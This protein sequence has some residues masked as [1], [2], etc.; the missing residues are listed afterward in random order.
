MA[1]HAVATHAVTA[2]ATDMHLQQVDANIVGHE[3]WT[4]KLGNRV[5]PQMCDLGPMTSD[6]DSCAAQMHFLPDAFL[7]ASN[8]GPRT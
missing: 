4:L 6:Q 5:G 7:G 8:A 2:H 3:P 1:V